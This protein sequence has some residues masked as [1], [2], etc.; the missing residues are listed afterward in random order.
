MHRAVRLRTPV[1]LV[2][3]DVMMPEMDG[4]MVAEKIRDEV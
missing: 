1:A 4:F 2:L 3:L